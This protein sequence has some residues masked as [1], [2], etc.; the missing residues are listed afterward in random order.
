MI[1]GKIIDGRAIIP[2]VFRLPSQPDFNLNFVID[3][4][5]N[6]HLTLPPQ[7]VSAMNLPLYS[8]TEARLADGTQALLSIHLATIVWDGIE[9]LV[10]V[11][12]AGYKPLLGTSLMAGYHLEID[13]QDNG[14]VSLEKL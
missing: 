4:G 8:S 11:L 13:F 5:F 9:R 14:L 1:Y 7:A 6:D 10:P 12:A 3:T 2:V